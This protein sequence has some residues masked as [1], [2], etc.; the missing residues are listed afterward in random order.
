V[1]TPTPPQRVSIPP[2]GGKSNLQGFIVLPGYSPGQVSD[3][4]VFRDRLVIQVEVYDPD[5][6][7]HDGAG[8]NNVRFTIER[9]DGDD[10]TL[11]QR[12]ENTPGYCAFGGGE[13]NCNV[14]VYAQTNNRWPETNLPIVDGP[15]RLFA[16]INR[17]NGETEIWNW[18]FEIRGALPQAPEPANIFA[19]IVQTGPGTTS[20]QVS[21]ALVFQVF[22]S[23]DGVNDGAGIDRVDMRIIGPHGE[24]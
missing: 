11:Y 7:N 8:I 1:P 3:P 5:F 18:G 21:D 24:V 22:A 2:D 9:D 4:M 19:Q 6:G 23:T 13:P 17:Q 15:H 20:K 14:L 16:Q 10:T 12:Q